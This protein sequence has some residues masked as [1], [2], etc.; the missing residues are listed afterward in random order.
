MERLC[1]LSP[2]G[3]DR[4]VAK[5]IRTSLHLQQVFICN[6]CQGHG[7]GKCTPCTRVLVRPGFLA[8]QFTVRI[9]WLQLRLTYVGREERFKCHAIS[10]ITVILQ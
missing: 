6:A 7:R 3:V 5:P 4:A 2:T 1:L 8:L 9:C 10:A